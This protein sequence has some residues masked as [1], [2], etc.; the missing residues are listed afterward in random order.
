M[1]FQDFLIHFAALQQGFVSTLTHDAAFVHNQNE[2]GVHY[3]THTL[4]ND[5]HRG[6]RGDISHGFAQVGIGFKVEGR[7]A[8]V[9]DI[10][11]G[12]AH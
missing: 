12:F 2:V 8:V 5:D 6:T 3:G 10:N 4:G 9:K 7:K 1:R 11:R